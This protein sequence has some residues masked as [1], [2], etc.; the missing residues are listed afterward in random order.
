MRKV[1]QD[2][3]VFFTPD[4]KSKTFKV[5]PFGPKNTLEFYT[6]IMQFLRDEWILLLNET[7]HIISLTKSPAKVIC[8]DHIIIDDILLFSTHT[9]TLLYYFSCVTRVFT[10]DI[11][12]HP[13]SVMRFLQGSSG[14]HR[15]RSNCQ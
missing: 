5:I 2:K 7:R 9:P 12:F 15:P 11:V 8:N 1:D 14:I 6:T 4:G 13:S 3:L 10:K